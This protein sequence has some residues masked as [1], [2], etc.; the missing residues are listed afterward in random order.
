MVRAFK[1]SPNQEP[2]DG[3]ADEEAC[4]VLEF[5]EIGHFNTWIGLREGFLPVWRGLPAGTGA[6]S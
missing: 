4:G 1:R 6:D 2:E 3:K 5:F